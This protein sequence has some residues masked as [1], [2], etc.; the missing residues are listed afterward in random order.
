MK[1]VYISSIVMF[2]KLSKTYLIDISNY[3]SVISLLTIHLKNQLNFKT[4]RKLS[5]PEYNSRV[6]M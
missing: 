3:A 2:I 4:S 1:T 6:N 5:Y